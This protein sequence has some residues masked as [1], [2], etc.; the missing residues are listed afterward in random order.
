MHG[1]ACM[2]LLEVCDLLLA[3]WNNHWVVTQAALQ[4]GSAALL[5]KP[6]PDLQGHLRWSAAAAFLPHG[7]RLHLVLLHS[8]A[9][10]AANEL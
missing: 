9:A 2:H 8:G 5:P 1:H 10:A 7:T 3:L 6:G 4:G